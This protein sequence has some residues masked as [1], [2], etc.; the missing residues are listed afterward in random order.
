[1]CRP[2][3]QY[4]RSQ[5]PQN[6][7][8]VGILGD[9]VSIGWTPDVASNLAHDASVQHIPFSGDGGA[10]DTKYQINCMQ[11]FTRSAEL[12]DTSYDVIGFNSGLHDVNYSGQYPEEYTPKPQYVSN[13]RIILQRLLASNDGPGAPPG[14]K[15]TRVIW[16]TTTP[17]PFSAARDDL[18]KE[19]NAAA[20]QVM[21]QDGQDRVTVVDLY[22]HVISI[23]GEPPYTSCNISN[24]SPSHPSPH[25]TAAG[26]Q[27][28]AS[29]VTKAVQEALQ[30]QAKGGPVGVTSAPVDPREGA[31][32]VGCAG[33]GVPQAKGNSSCF[34]GTSG[35]M[36]DSWSYSGFGCCELSA[37]ATY[38]ED[39]WHCCPAGTKCMEGC[40][41][42]GCGCVPA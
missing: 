1:M 5:L 26:Y 12:L 38:C 24:T 20:L 32:P 34:S 42:H 10:L 36:P 25:Y 9:S 6:L 16:V 3:A 23:C 29:F 17:V 27:Y 41:L 21:Q 19:Y 7:P 30:A 40:S 13:L 14:V 22:T 35:C 28:L 11:Y 37:G 2:G 18:V 8:S 15:P 33:Q 39:D 31:S 4:A